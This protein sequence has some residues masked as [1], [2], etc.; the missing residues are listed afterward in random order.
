MLFFLGIP[1]IRD[2]IIYLFSRLFAK[3]VQEDLKGQNFFLN[4]LQVL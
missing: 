4:F 1:C 2:L 3:L